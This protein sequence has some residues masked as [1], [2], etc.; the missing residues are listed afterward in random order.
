MNRAGSGDEFARLQRVD[1]LCRRRGAVSA[2]RRQNYVG[3]RHLLVRAWSC[4]AIHNTKGKLLE[5][6]VEDCQLESV[7]ALAMD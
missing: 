7:Q 2:C 4:I 6:T 1:W 5:S 3:A